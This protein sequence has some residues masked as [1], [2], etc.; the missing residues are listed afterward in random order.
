MYLA[1]ETLSEGMKTLLDG[2]KAVHCAAR[3][4]GP[5]G[6]IVTDDDAREMVIRSTPEALAEREH[7]V[8]RT[9]PET[10]RKCLY[11]NPTYTTRFSDMSEV[12]SAPLLH[13]LFRHS[14]RPEFTGR[15]RWQENSLALWDNR[16]AMHFAVND[17]MGFRRVMH[18]VTVAGDRPM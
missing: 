13:F 9:H 16:C 7:P 6:T 1:Y 18:R 14:V 17:Y 10:G 15:F 2:L 4:Y 11:V 5:K 12:E 8:V 3:H